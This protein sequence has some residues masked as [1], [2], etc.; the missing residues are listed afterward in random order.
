LR[1]PFNWD[2]RPKPGAKVI[3]AGAP[4]GE[5]DKP[6]PETPLVPGEVLGK[7]PDIGAYENN[8]KHYWIPGRIGRQASTPVPPNGAKDVLPDA[9]LMFL[10]GRDATSHVVYLGTAAERLEKKAELTDT[11]I[12]SP[13]KL[14]S[15]GIYYWR[16]DAVRD[17]KTVK[18][19][20]WRFTV[21]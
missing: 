13:G 7:A 5:K 21:K 17:G 11:N 12:C 18:G 9:D 14:K 8:T 16:V 1:D 3:D 10:G 20:V 4:L 15:G 2:F 19:A 6:S